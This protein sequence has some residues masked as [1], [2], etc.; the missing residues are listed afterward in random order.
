MRLNAPKGNLLEQICWQEL[1][2]E[3]HAAFILEPCVE[4]DDVGVGEL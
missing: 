3:A 2:D 4:L 1:Q